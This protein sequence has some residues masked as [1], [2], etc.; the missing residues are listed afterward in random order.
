MNFNSRLARSSLAIAVVCLSACGAVRK[1]ISACE[2][3]G[4]IEP[5]CHLSNPEDM[6]L[7]PDN[8]TLVISQI[9]HINSPSAG[10]LVWFDTASQVVTAAFPA[11]PQAAS[12]PGDNWGMRA[13]PGVPGAEFS[14]IGISLRQRHDGRW[15]LAAVNQGQRHSVEMFEVLTLGGAYSLAWRGCVI[16]PDGTNLNDVA[17]MRN[18]G[19][20]ASHMFDRRDPVVFGFSTG[21]WKA[22]L[23]INTGYAL[24]WLPEAGGK[25]RV[26]PESHGPFLNGIQLSADDTTVFVSVT[27]GDEIFKLD[28]ASGKKLA[29]AKVVRPDNLSWDRDGHLL[30]ASLGGG[31]FEHL[32]CLRHPGANCGLAFS[33]VRIDPRTMATETLFQHEGAPMGAA[34]VAQPVGDW[35]FLGSFTGDR[36]IKIPYPST[37]P[38]KS[39]A[40]Q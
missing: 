10:K 11:P 18:G 9:G 31:K 32:D 33:I 40:L 2:K 21:I 12:V 22:Q 8:R 17:L 35:L 28:R 1:P 6:E 19:F 15:Q 30:V 14:P 16:T 7:L 29:T 23:G 26:L 27:S 25:F 4:D 13:C 20:V 3:M 39:T 34:T 5:I 24:E 38:V 36:I 37:P